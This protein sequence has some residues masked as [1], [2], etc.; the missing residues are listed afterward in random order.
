MALAGP[1]LDRPSA[2]GDEG[3]SR[4]TSLA[5]ATL[6]VVALAVVVGVGIGQP[7]L[8]TGLGTVAGLGI[9]AI[10]LLDRAG[11]GELFVGHLLLVTFGSA[12][13]LVA[14]V[15]PFFGRLGVVVSG[16]TIALTGIAMAWADVGG[17]DMK[18]AASGCALTYG[19]ML[20]SAIFVAIG[21]ALVMLVVV[22]LE[23]VGETTTPVGSLFGFLLVSLVTGCFVL[24]SLQLLPIRQL[25][26]RNRRDRVTAWLTAFQRLLGVALFGAFVLLVVTIVLLVTGVLEDQS[27]HVSIV[28]GALLQL[29]S[30]VVIWATVAVGVTSLAAGT[31]AVCLRLITRRFGEDATRW[32]AAVVAGI[33]LVGFVLIALVILFV[34]LLIGNPFAILPITTIGTLGAVVLLFGPPAFL[35]LVG[36]LLVGSVLGVVPNRVLGPAIGAFGLVIVA[37]G[38]GASSPVLVFACLAGAAIVWD[39]STFGLALTAELG[40]VPE[41]RRLELFHGLVSV[42]IAVGVVLVAT[43]LESLRTGAFGDVGSAGAAIAIGVGALLLLVPLRG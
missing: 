32:S 3:R 11:F 36:V 33:S 13:A 5:I 20:F 12:L 19:S 30:P 28:D 24:V 41:T 6:V 21:A 16:F 39:V 29:S 2:I 42:G 15:A 23:A 34:G 38:L 10:A 43:G 4:A 40:H 37:I 26:A 1:R 25:T 14:L 17:D 18:R 9:A 8:V 31:V 35:L 7:S 27:F 22:L